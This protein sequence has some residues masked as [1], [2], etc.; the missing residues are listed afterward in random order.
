MKVLLDHDVPHSLRFHFPDEHE[1]VTA[2]YRGWEGYDGDALLAAA[3]R[4]F[5]VFVTLDTNLAH[6]QNV[7]SLEIG[8]VVI[9]VHP[10]IPDHLKRHMAKVTSALSI[11]AGDQGVVVVREDGIVLRSP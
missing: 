1:V 10:V 2:H 7:R 11:A 4:E 9:D 8:I 5:V 6:Q 3:E